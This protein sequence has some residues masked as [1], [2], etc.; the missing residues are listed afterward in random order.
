M[1]NIE[2][3]MRRAMA[4]GKFDDLPGKGKPLHLDQ[5]NPH[6]DPEWELAYRMLRESGFSLPWIE[7]IKE[8]EKDIET[9]RKELQRAWKWRIIYLSAEVPDKK[10]SAEWERALDAFMEKLTTLNQRI[11][12][13]NLQVPNARFQR[14]VLSYT[15]EV[16]NITGILGN[17]SS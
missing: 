7:I 6:A 17:P 14:P 8:I 2:E 1:P 9:A 13:Y 5:S 11:R 3:L 12:D 15:R 10:A 16:E 4:E